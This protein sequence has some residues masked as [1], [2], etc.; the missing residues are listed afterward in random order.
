MQMR[1]A[2]PLGSAEADGGTDPGTGSTTAT[3]DVCVG[4]KPV[5]HPFEGILQSA[6][7]EQE[8]FLKMAWTADELGVECRFCHVPHP[9]D[10]KK[11]DY[12]VQT[13]RKRIAN[14]MSTQLMHAVK[15]ADGS[16]M[17]CRSCHVDDRGNPLLKILGS[18]R[19][20]DRA[21]EWMSLVM[22]NKFLSVKGE[23]LKCKSCHGGNFGT[24]LW[25]AKVILR[26]EQLPP[27]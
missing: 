8:M 25:Q 26:T 10:P 22:V 24:N 6:R 16:P 11:E 1:A 4:S 19:N 18:P 27:H 20:P 7:C 3:G 23:K 12:P 21:H 14:W 2:T 15:P 17:R 9:T 13:E 5:P